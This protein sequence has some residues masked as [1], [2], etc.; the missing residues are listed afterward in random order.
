MENSEQQRW[1]QHSTEERERN[2]QQGENERRKERYEDTEDKV[3]VAHYYLLGTESHVWISIT[4]AT[5][6]YC[7]L[8]YVLFISQGVLGR[9]SINA[10]NKIEN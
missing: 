5:S 7:Y 1:Y 4:H 10:D 2:N 8:I 6:D 3:S 9:L